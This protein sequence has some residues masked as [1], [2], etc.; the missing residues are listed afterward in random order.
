MKCPLEIFLII[1]YNKNICIC[2]R[3]KSK[4]GSMVISMNKVKVTVCG[5]EFA[6]Q[7]E[8]LPSYFIGLAKKLDRDIMRMVDIGDNI[9][10]QSAAML[11][12]LSSY[13]EAQKANDSIDNIRTQIKEYVD[14][15]CRA[16]SERDEAV[17][18]LSTLK[19]KIANLENEIN[20]QKLKDNVDEQLTMDNS[21]HNRK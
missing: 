15:A 2:K 12:A 4:R 9:S 13:D 19:A 1:Y 17:K 5:K 18:E 8:E 14:D 6:L 7:T 20:F 3:K 10:V 16:R 21:S 11:A